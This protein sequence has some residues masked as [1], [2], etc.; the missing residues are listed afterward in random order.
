MHLYQHNM[1]HTQNIFGPTLGGDLS[2][3]AGLYEIMATHYR[4]KKKKERNI[5]E[6]LKQRQQ[7]G[8]CR[9]SIGQSLTLGSSSLLKKIL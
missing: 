1:I 5:S 3:V 6:G 9:T 2:H 4:K 8:C 7:Y